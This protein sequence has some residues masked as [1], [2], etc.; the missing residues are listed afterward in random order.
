M[1]RDRIYA[2]QEGKN[3]FINSHNFGQGQGFFCFE[4]IENTIFFNV[5]TEGIW[6]KWSIFILKNKTQKFKQNNTNAQKKN[7]KT[8]TMGA[9]IIFYVSSDAQG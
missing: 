8:N 2:F 3:F 5:N 9:A 1:D 7:N 4:S 6:M